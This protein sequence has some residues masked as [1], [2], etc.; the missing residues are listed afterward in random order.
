MKSLDSSIKYRI[1]RAEKGQRRTSFTKKLGNMCYCSTRAPVNNFFGALFF[2]G[3]E[4]SQ[5]TGGD[6]NTQ[7][8]STKYTHTHISTRVDTHTHMYTST[9]FCCG[10]PFGGEKMGVCSGNT[11]VMDAQ[12]YIL[13][14]S[15]FERFDHVCARRVQAG[16]RV[17]TQKAKAHTHT[18][19]H[20][21]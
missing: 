3:N 11:S 20:A 4:R 6:M 19:V 12:I 13:H 8:Y 7:L 14:L 15:V 2:L 16:T 9:I 5:R 10:S 21:H 18:H 17:I 1:Y